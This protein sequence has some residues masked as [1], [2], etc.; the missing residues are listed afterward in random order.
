MEVPTKEFGNIAHQAT[1]SVLPWPHLVDVPKD[2]RG[3]FNEKFV[4]SLLTMVCT[5]ILI[6]VPFQKLP[7]PE[8]PQQARGLHQLKACKSNSREL[9]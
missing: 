3:L 1:A 4:G 7:Y 9:R 2:L 6:R 5:H 8:V